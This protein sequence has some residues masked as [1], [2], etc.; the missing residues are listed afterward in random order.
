MTTQPITE[1]V[2]QTQEILRLAISLDREFRSADVLQA[3][4]GDPGNTRRDL[5]RMREDAL[6]VAVKED[7]KGAW[8]RLTDQAHEAIAALDRAMG[9]GVVTGLPVQPLDKIL[10]NPAN[11]RKSI[12]AEAL[13][14]FAETIV[15][16][17]GLVQPIV[18]YPADANGDRMLH[19]GT[20]R[21]LA[22]R[23]LQDEGRLPEALANGLPFIERE[24]TK[25][26]ALLI[27]LIENGQRENLT[28]WEDA[29]ALKDYQLETGLSA[30]AIAFA[31][32]RAKEGG[33]DTGVRDVQSKIRTATQAT[34]A[35]IALHESGVWTWEQLRDSA[36]VST[37]PAADPEPV[38]P[39]Q[40]DIEDTV[41]ESARPSASSPSAELEAWWTSLE[42]TASEVL[43]L[44]ELQARIRR[45]QHIAYGR[46]RLFQP[47]PSGFERK[48]NRILSPLTDG[49]KNP[50][51]AFLG[52]TLEGEKLLQH[53][54]IWTEFD[55]VDGAVNRARQA[56][57]AW[58][59]RGLALG[60]YATEWLSFRGMVDQAPPTSPA[61]PAAQNA[62]TQRM[63]EVRSELACAHAADAS[64]EDRD[65]EADDGALTTLIDTLKEALHQTLG[66]AGRWNDPDL[67]LHE[68]AALAI[69]QT[70]RLDITEAL[71]SLMGLLQRAG[72]GFEAT[73]V[74]HA[75]VEGPNRPE[76][77][78]PASKLYRAGRRATD[79]MVQHY[80][81]MHALEGVDDLFRDLSGALN[82]VSNAKFAEPL[83]VLRA[84]DVVEKYPGGATAH[85]LIERSPSD[86]PRIVF[87]AQPIRHGK[88]YGKPAALAL[89]EIAA[90]ARPTISN[91][92]GEDHAAA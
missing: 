51:R 16:A 4:G 65:E 89:T 19:A 86:G 40:T 61:N 55:T 82:D 42:P 56:E 37:P 18:L 79:F 33:K 35:N 17:K 10:E 27:G 11:P 78:D 74:L 69:H 50:W 30:R 26:E 91:Q 41:E 38:E 25:A 20:R 80:D 2:L 57:G 53:L 3:L 87:R 12:D 92:K 60:E 64:R 9:S 68:L 45:R 70:L 39:V 47:A 83:L 66:T 77:Q 48:F 62:V 14:L 59:W 21:T 81:E 7:A 22:C 72:D 67:P 71:V 43:A 84:G 13:A 24:G 28:P 15:T 6:I 85:R 75:A 63:A 54:R 88:V 8:Y 58:S 23:L 29:Q 52:L 44:V 32:G 34:A 73:R 49:T 36:S 31:I 1:L 90:F 46:A 5:R 76:G